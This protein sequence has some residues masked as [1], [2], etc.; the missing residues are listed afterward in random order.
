MNRGGPPGE[1]RRPEFVQYT[2][3]FFDIDKE[4]RVTKKVN[5]CPKDCLKIR[6]DCL[7]PG[8]MPNYPAVS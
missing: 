5:K 3:C 4:R 7:Q 1:G 8:R 2:V 6:Q